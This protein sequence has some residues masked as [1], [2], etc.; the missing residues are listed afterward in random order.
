MRCGV[1]GDDRFAFR[2]GA[3]GCLRCQLHHHLD[4][5]SDGADPV[6]VAQL[7][8]FL[9]GLR[10]ADNPRAALD[11]ISKRPVARTVV[12][13]MLHGRVPVS[14]K[15]LDHAGA[16]PDATSAGIEYLRQLLVD[17]HV[18]PG[19]HEPL[20]RVERTIARR[21]D[22][23][24]GP[25]AAALRRYA[26]WQVL[27]AVRRPRHPQ[28]PSVLSV[29]AALRKFVTAHTFCA[30]IESRGADLAHLDQALVD[31]WVTEHP[32]RAIEL[33]TFTTWAARQHLGPAVHVEPRPLS[34]PANFA[35]ADDQL[36]AV[37]A[38]LTDDT[39]PAR[40][41]LAGA[42]LL[43]Y[44]QPLSRIT[45]LRRSDLDLTDGAVSIRLGPTPLALPEPLAQLARQIAHE[46]PA[47]RGISRGFAYDSPWLFPGHPPS[48]PIDASSLRNRLNRRLSLPPARAARN[49][50]LITLARD[51]PP[52]V[53][54]DLLGLSAGTAEQ[55][56]QLAGGRWTS[57]VAHR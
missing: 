12:T 25:D 32:H 39:V 52:V 44:G 14:H 34:Y 4:R 17:S 43:L 29:K 1:C 19:R 40:D 38:C 57:Y 48:R 26:T 50:A 54:A 9:D 46:T 31:T 56:H 33:A 37:R 5:L 30:W 24:S 16:R 3:R 41:R 49:T 42:L 55:W 53:L 45:Q 35:P 15:T 18:L 21:L 27:P 36:S 11:W 28:P 10:L 8:P 6:R 7:R 23:C 20:S 2:V 51:V 22:T 47:A 13:D